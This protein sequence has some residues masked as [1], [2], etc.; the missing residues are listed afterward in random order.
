[1]ITKY[2]GEWKKGMFNGKGNLYKNTYYNTTDPNLQKISGYG[3]INKNLQYWYKGN[4]VDSM[5]HGY[6]KYKSDSKKFKGEFEQ[7]VFSG[8][9]ELKVID[10]SDSRLIS[11][12]IGNFMNGKYSG[13]GKLWVNL[14][15]RK[16]KK[17]ENFYDGKWVDGNAVGTF[18]VSYYKSKITYTGPL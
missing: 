5:F 15:K 13:E 6:G 11:R 16:G 12:Y 7:N 9:G 2:K 18:I 3:P 17:K 4:F 14:G 10:P 8:S 1:M